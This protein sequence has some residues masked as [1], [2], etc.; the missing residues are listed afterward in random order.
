MSDYTV[1]VDKKKKTLTI[2]LPLEDKPTPSASGKNL[3]IASTH[4]TQRT[5]ELYDGKPITIGVN[6]FIPPR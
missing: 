2:V 1:T 3:T 5:S 6:A 4:G